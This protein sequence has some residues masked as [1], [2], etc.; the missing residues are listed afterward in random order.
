MTKF[1]YINTNILNPAG[2]REQIKLG[3]LPT[4]I[5]RHFEIYCKYDYYRKQG[6]K[7]YISVGFASEDYR[8]HDVTILRII[9]SMETEL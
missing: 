2:I 4:K 5:I 9:K 3:I 1:E 8:L 7:K 6:Y